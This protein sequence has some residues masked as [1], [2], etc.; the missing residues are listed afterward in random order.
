MRTAF[1]SW[2]RNIDLANSR[3]RRYGNLKI[4]LIVGAVITGILALWLMSVWIG[5]ARRRVESDQK[6]FMTRQ[7]LERIGASVP[8]YQDSYEDTRPEF[9]FGYDQQQYSWMTG[10]LPFIEQPRIYEML[11]LNKPWGS[12]ENAAGFQH[13]IPTYLNYNA[14]EQDC[15]VGKLRAAHF[16]GNSQ[17]IQATTGRSFPEMR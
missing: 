15:R 3:V 4:A 10:L 16:A 17:V 11:D 1:R 12:Q 13:N 5:W 9:S 7:S 6:A 8:N 14:Q 2:H